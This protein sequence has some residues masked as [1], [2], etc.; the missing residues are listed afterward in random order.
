MLALAAHELSSAMTTFA[1]D[2]DVVFGTVQVVLTSINTPLK[3]NVLASDSSLF[4]IEANLARKR[5]STF[6][7]LVE[8]FGAFRMPV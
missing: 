1:A 3:S 4:G 7:R 6:A 2:R 8:F 5:L